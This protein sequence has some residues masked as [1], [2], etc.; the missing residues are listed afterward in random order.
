MDNM[1]F[2]SLESR[3]KTQI[4]G[5]MSIIKEYEHRM[6]EETSQHSSILTDK[7]D[8]IKMLME[9][10]DKQKEEMD[11]FLKVS[12]ASKWKKQCEEA[13]AKKSHLE[14]KL[15]DIQRA[16]VELNHRLD[17]MSKQ[18]S[19]ETQT[20]EAEETCDEQLMKTNEKLE[21]TNKAAQKKNRELTKLN[22]ELQETIVKMENELIQ[23]QT[24][25]EN[26]E[27]QETINSLE[28]KLDELTKLNKELQDQVVEPGGCEDNTEELQ[29]KINDL[30]KQLSEVPED[31]TEELQNKIN[32]LEKQLSEVPEDNTEELQ[33]KIND[34]EGINVKNYDKIS[35]L[36]I[37]L[38]NKSCE[39]TIKT[40]KG[41]VYT[42][43]DDKL[44]KDGKVVGE[45]VEKKVV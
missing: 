13:E 43:K 31:N 35:E 15:E 16:N 9:I 24:P 11:D 41:A 12:F 38:G 36:E 39:M 7:D 33:N 18:E 1:E 19:I 40:Q 5:L 44:E 22:K 2:L 45:V 17:Q 21:K 32:D 3:V 10:R 26:E 6:N 8:Q 23:E 4:E 25:Q 28:T 29:S 34:L 42:L 27:L 20:D 14:M 37:E 30:E